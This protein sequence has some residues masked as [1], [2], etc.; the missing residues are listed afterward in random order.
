MEL[1]L[2][3]NSMVEVA[4]IDPHSNEILMDTRPRRSA[5]LPAYPDFRRLVGSNPYGDKLRLLMGY[6]KFR[7]CQL[8]EDLVKGGKPVLLVRTLILS[9]KIRTFSTARLRM[10]AQV[11]AVFAI[12]GVVCLLLLLW[13]I[14]F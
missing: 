11:V 8:E 2:I 10:N 12:I 1:T 7:Y 3:S 14:A 13:A 6:D 4:V 5:I 9:D